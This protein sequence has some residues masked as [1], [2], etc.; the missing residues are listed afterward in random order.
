MKKNITIKNIDVDLYNQIKA[1][2]ESEA[3]SVS[4]FIT[5][6][7]TKELSETT[8]KDQSEKIEKYIAEIQFQREERE[9]ALE[10]LES[11]K[12]ENNLLKSNLA[13]KT[14]KFES[15]QRELEATKQKLK[16]TEEEIQAYKDQA[17]QILTITSGEIRVPFDELELALLNFVCERE[18][19]RVN[20]EITPEKLLNKM[21]VNHA[22]KGDMYFFKQPTRAEIYKLK[23]NLEKQKEYGEE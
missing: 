21:F 9:K 17:E 5:S 7:F 13:L 4:D 12:K 10:E 19:K 6:L 18:T 16:V 1:K 2:A 22:V 8:D 23:E 3:V 14:Q 11:F 15:S 20:E